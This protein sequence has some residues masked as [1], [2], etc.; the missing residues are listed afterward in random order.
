MPTRLC[1]GDQGRCPDE[2]VYRG[3]CRKHSRENE[4]TINR[5]G[6]ELYRTT[7]W[8]RT[9]EAY[10]FEH[11]LCECGC[12][13]LSTDVHHKTDLDAGG[14]PWSFTNLQALSHACHSRISRA[15]QVESV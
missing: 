14:D 5:A 15:R 11:P 4:R 3:K 8:K 2:A 1:N 7:R 9:R 12:G 10:L 6:R 13:A